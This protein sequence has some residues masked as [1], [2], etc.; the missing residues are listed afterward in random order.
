VNVSFHTYTEVCLRD[1]LAALARE[2]LPRFQERVVYA[3]NLRRGRRADTDAPLR[4][5]EMLLELN[6]FLD[7]HPGYDA[8]AESGDSLFGGLELRLRAGGLYFSQNYYASMGFAVPAAIGAEIGR[9]RRA[10]VLCG[11]GAFQ[12]TGPEIS[13]APR[14]GVAPI[15]VLVNNSG[16]QIFRPVSPRPE[17]LEVPAWPYA[18]LAQQ[19]GGVGLQARTRGEL[20]E[21]LCAAHERHVFS[22]I[23]CRI[24]PGDLSPISRAYIR[25]SASKGRRA[26][27]AA[28]GRRA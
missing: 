13:H 12:M 9:G 10:L 2:K 16:W 3:D 23:E 22:V 27:K 18:E 4:V 15:V 24:T 14:H 6:H 8:F 5:N 28:K 19:W 26:A 20:R 21:A 25:E 7:G 1:F 11:D 17:L